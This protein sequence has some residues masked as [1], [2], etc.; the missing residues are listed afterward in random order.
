MNMQKRIAERMRCVVA[1]RN[2]LGSKEM[3]L[4]VELGIHK[5][6]TGSVWMGDMENDE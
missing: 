1:V 6:V 4:K 3:S 2:A 5:T